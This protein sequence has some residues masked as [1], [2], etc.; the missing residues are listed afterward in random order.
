MSILNVAIIGTGGITLQNHLPGLALCRDVRVHAL[1]DANPATLETARQQTGAAI[2]A[3]SW[4][5]I[6]IRDDVHAVIIATPNFLHPEIAIAA[7]Q[8]GK[9]ILCEKPLALNA[10]DAQRM[11]DEA[12]RAGVRHMTAFTYRFVPAMRYLSHLIDQGELGTPYHYRC[13]R[14][15]DWG[16]RNLGWRQVRKFAGTGEIGDMLSHRINFAQYLVGP[17]RR[18]V[19]N[20]KN[21]TP[22]R[23]GA[24]NDTDDWVAI[25]AEFTNQATGVLESSKLAS[26]HN[27]SWRSLDH[28]ELNG[29]AATFQFTTGKWN[30][31]QAGR[32]GGSG[33]KP[34]SV[35]PEFWVWPGSPRDPSV[36][37]PLVSFR[38][39]QAVE[40][41]NAIREQRPCAIPF[42]DGVAA[43]RVMDAAVKSTEVGQWV[44]VSNL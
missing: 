34:L 25:L 5:D 4:Q 31:L 26:G 42:N 43:Q 14:L 37:D 1:C 41:I 22:V 16:T 40:F 8:H 20:L 10:T 3:T 36:G 32:L 28:V 21:R 12:E 35:P 24:P 18:L 29:S 33:L 11:L 27:E 15:Q 19:A 39:D 7:A 6:V 17:V 30:E 2:Y 23:D 9:H 13:L 38:Y 44:E